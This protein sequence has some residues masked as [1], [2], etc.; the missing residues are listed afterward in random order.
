[1]MYKNYTISGA[2]CSSLKIGNFNFLHHVGQE[3]EYRL[4]RQPPTALSCNPYDFQL[5][6]TCTVE[7]PNTPTF[8][9][10][11]FSRRNNRDEELQDSQQR[12]EID[13]MVTPDVGGTAQFTRRSS[14]LALSPLDEVNDVGQ[15]WCQVRLEN[16][17]LFHEK[18]NI[19]TLSTE[20]QY[21]DLIHCGSTDGQ[22]DQIDCLQMLQIIGPSDIDGITL[23]TTGSVVPPTA[24]FNL[25]LTP[26]TGS[27]IEEPK[28][29]S[30]N[31]AALYAVIAVIVMFAMLIILLSTALD[32][33]RCST[34]SRATHYEGMDGQPEKQQV[35]IEHQLHAPQTSPVNQN[36]AIDLNEN[37]AY[38]SYH[39][40]DQAE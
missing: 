23:T 19:L 40:E 30:K 12:V 8:S 17:T 22:V 14:R 32:I 31:L 33:L 29:T 39:G 9:I 5:A 34:S 13:V 26:T 36:E 37:V 4:T 21:L 35:T 15:Y 25:S 27:P 7:G 18:S 1:M 24:S 16:G 3:C 6:L 2:Y 28:N 38:H 11:W 10:I 20:E